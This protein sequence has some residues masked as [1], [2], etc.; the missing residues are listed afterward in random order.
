MKKSLVTMLFILVPAVLFAS[1]A[2]VFYDSGA[3]PR[4]LVAADINSDGTDE[5]VVANFGA[6]TLIGQDNTAPAPTSLAVFS[7]NNSSLSASLT[8]LTGSL[9]GLAAGDINGDGKTDIAATNYAE[10]T[11]IIFLQENRVLK[12]VTA[13]ETGK[14]PVGVAIGNCDND[15]ENEIAVAVYGENKVAIV[16]YDNG[17]FSVSYVAAGITPTDVAIGKYKGVN[18]II[19]ANYG[20]GGVSVIVKKDG[21]Y[22]VAEEIKTGSGTCKVEAADTDKDGENEII[23]ANFNDN[24]VSVID[25][26]NV[27][28]LKLKGERPNGMAVGDINADGYA[29]I[30]TADRDSNSVEIALNVNGAFPLTE[31][32]TV[33]EDTDKTFGPVEAAIAD[34]NNDGAADILFTHMKSGK[35]GVIYGTPLPK[36]AK[37]EGAEPMTQANVYNYPNPASE[38]TTIR[39]PLEE[40]ADT[41]IT[42]TDINGI[43][44]WEKKLSKAETKAGVN[45]V[46][47]QLVNGAGQKIGNGAYVL[48]VKSGNKTITKNIAVVK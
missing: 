41:V 21:V 25:G 42:V 37:P 17:G 3:F 20:G 47:W 19:S 9:R 43:K 27:S 29:D 22:A 18:S 16:D 4:G 38:S 11:V 39:F 2:P 46:I 32:I 26:L 10:G 8:E 28:T 23:A 31:N 30:I 5:A 36:G 13:V 35:L 14:Y 7:G 48:K 40:A 1:A 34:I 12:A 15:P 24:T 33:N 45:T 44:V 6:T